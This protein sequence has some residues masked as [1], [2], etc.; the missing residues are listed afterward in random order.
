MDLKNSTALVT[1]ATG[2]IG[3]AITFE[4]SRA[5]AQ[6]IICG[7]DIQGLTDLSSACSG[8][9]I[10]G[11]LGTPSGIDRLA[12][13]VLRIRNPVDVLVNNAGIG[14]AG[15]FAAMP[16]TI[17]DEVVAV[18]VLG[19][20]RLTRAL[21]PPMLERRRGHIVN[22]ASIGGHLGVRDESV[23]AATK[24]AVL[25]FSESLRY[26]VASRGVKVSTVTP[27]VVD[28]P[29]FAKRGTPYRRRRPRPISPDR[30]AS[31]IVRAIQEEHDDIVEPAWLRL[32]IWLR[33]AW[34]SLY[35]KLARRFG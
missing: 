3:R 10:A 12:E 2:G 19:L 15:S 18:N 22:V 31:A 20:V 11:D 17:I 9:A 32:P 28:T 13:A 21:L 25:T 24:A 29:F 33:G 27:G 7:R 26:E 30:I 23:Y 8:T 34:P 14:W 5:G 6:V 16:T 35:R 4:L 1:G